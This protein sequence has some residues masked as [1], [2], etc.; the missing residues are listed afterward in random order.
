LI[1]KVIDNSNASG[2][3]FVIK[4]L[5]Y[6]FGVPTFIVQGTSPA[7]KGLLTYQGCG[8]GT[9]VNPEKALI[10]A[11]S[12]Y[13]ESFSLIRKTQSQIDLDWAEI[14]EKMPPR[15][16]GFLVLVNQDMFK[17]GPKKV[18]LSELKD[19]SQND[20]KLEIESI[21]AVLNS[22]GYEIIYLDKTYPKL[23]I[24]AARIYCPQMR[25]LIV[26]E[27]RDPWFVMSEVMAEAGLYGSSEKHLRQSLARTSFYL[28][29]K[30]HDLTPKKLF[31]SD[32]RE[33][34]SF[35]GGLKKDAL[36]IVKYY[37]KA[38]QKADKKPDK[39]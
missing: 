17:P 2:I 15:H 21:V 16:L 8:H 29:S 33:T 23:G 11:L 38:R 10:R 28:P 37:A 6:D 32:Y 13:F 14:I 7:D 5:S 31:K 30:A 12:E 26:S 25:N 36:E 34:L 1:R 4:D 20:I 3:T 39:K 9:H 27:C 18:K 19:W 24:P 35:Y 22:Q